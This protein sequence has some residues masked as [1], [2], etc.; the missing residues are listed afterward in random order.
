MAQPIVKRTPQKCS[1]GDDNRAAA[2]LIAKL[3]FD[4][5][6]PLFFDEET[7]DFRLQN[8]DT[9]CLFE[10]IFHAALIADLIALGT[11]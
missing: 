1:G 11:G 9:G 6:N 3:V 8:I 5:D 4:A 2:D 7:G 10:Q